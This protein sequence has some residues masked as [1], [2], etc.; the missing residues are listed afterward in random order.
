[1]QTVEHELGEAVRLPGSITS[2]DHVFKVPLR[3]GLDKSKEAV[4]GGE[5]VDL[6]ES[7]IEVFARCRTYAGSTLVVSA[8]ARVGP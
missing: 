6:W 8:L 7:T 2:L 5:D 3:W 1:M 4:T